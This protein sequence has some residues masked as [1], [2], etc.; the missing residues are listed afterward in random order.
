LRTRR[1]SEAYATP[2]N[3]ALH[4]QGS[5]RPVAAGV[6]DF[7]LLN[8]DKR[9]SPSGLRYRIVEHIIL[10]HDFGSSVSTAIALSVLSPSNGSMLASFPFEEFDVWNNSLK[11][12]RRTQSPRCSG[13]RMSDVVLSAAHTRTLLCES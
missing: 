10:A 9:E 7:G 2:P 6:R 1:V 3:S 11:D 12:L 5:P 8:R 4:G 13:L